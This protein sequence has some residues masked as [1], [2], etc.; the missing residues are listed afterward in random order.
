MEVPGVKVARFDMPK[1]FVLSQKAGGT[2]GKCPLVFM[3]PT[4]EMEDVDGNGAAYP[5]KDTL[6]S[7]SR[8]L[9]V[10]GLA[11]YRCILGPLPLDVKKLLS[12]YRAS[13]S[14]PWVDQERVALLGIAFGADVIAKHYY[15]F[16]AVCRPQAAA[17]LS[18]SVQPIFLNNITCPYLVLHGQ[19]DPLFRIMPY[20]KIKE[21][22]FH[23]Q[24]RYGDSTV[25]LRYIGLGRELG[26]QN[27]IST[28]VIKQTVTWLET[29]I[30]EGLRPQ[31]PAAR[32]AA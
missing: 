7:L 11:T 16:Y 8:A 19:R 9:T 12:Y 27:M 24:M 3:L 14:Q 1:D 26:R 15:D 25:N 4:F 5:I 21:A 17:L 31:E 6:L 10:R 20:E 18:P 28:E 23:H 13:L 29:A 22:V 2:G 30:L 32:A